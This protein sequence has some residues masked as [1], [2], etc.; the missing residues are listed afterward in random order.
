M[1]L[2]GFA[3]LLW[4]SPSQ[5]YSSPD[6]WLIHAPV[7]FAASGLPRLR[8]LAQSW[9]HSCSFGVCSL[10]PAPAQVAGSDLLR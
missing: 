4:S 10:R 5:A 6:R 1:T 7:K 2:L 8:S 3:V 9:I